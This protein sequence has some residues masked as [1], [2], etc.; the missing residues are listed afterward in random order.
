MSLFA[1]IGMGDG[2][3]AAGC[4]HAVL[5]QETVKGL[6]RDALGELGPAVLLPAV[7]PP[8]PFLI[9]HVMELAAHAALQEHQDLRDK[10]RF[11]QWVWPGCLSLGK[12][13]PVEE[14][15]A[16]PEGFDISCVFFFSA[17]MARCRPCRPHGH[18]GL[19]RAL[20]PR[21]CSPLLG[22]PSERL[23]QDSQMFPLDPDLGGVIKSSSWTPLQSCPVPKQLAYHPSSASGRVRGRRIQDVL[24]HGRVQ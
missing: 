14:A 12:A 16:S 21:L 24:N 17:S 23:C 4:T 6:G 9:S 3:E 22:L 10:G 5:V 15:P 13:P 1:G 19:A 18:E 7:A 20:R 8:G 11:P 2:R